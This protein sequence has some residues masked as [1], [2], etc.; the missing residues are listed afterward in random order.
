MGKLFLPLLL[1]VLGDLSQTQGYDRHIE[2]CSCYYSLE[3]DRL[4][5]VAMFCHPS[6]AGLKQQALTQTPTK[7]PFKVPTVKTKK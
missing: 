6:A 5:F 4:V 3:T 7:P 2:A 1:G